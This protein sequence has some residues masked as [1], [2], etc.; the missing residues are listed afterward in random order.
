[1]EHEGRSDEGLLGKFSLLKSRP[2]KRPLEI[3]VMFKRW[4]LFYN[5]EET[6]LKV[7]TDIENSVSQTFWYQ[8]PLIF[9]NIFEDLK[10]LLFM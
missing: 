6:R 1:M 9:L 7:K 3:I 2:V 8:D 10:D 4:Q 5:H